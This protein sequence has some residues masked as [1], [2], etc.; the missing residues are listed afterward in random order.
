MYPVVSLESSEPISD[1]WM[2]DPT[3]RI[4][5]VNAYS[6]AGVPGIARIRRKTCH[7]NSGE[8]R[9]TI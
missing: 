9:G 4:W 2:E 3:V 6:R 1:R 8:F 7:L 5:I